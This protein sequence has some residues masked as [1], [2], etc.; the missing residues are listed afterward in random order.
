MVLHFDPKRTF[1]QERKKG[2]FMRTGLDS[3][4]AANAAAGFARSGVQIIQEEFPTVLI[5]YRGYDCT[6][7]CASFFWYP[8]CHSCLYRDN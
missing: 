3:N 4:H 7:S 2:Q 6:F 1:G 8:A 5:R